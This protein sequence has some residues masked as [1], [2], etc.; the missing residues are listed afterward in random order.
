MQ[1][2]RL[3]NAGGKWD[4][5]ILKNEIFVQVDKMNVYVAPTYINLEKP[6]FWKPRNSGEQV[7]KKKTMFEN[8]NIVEIPE[9]REDS[10]PSERANGQDSGFIDTDQEEAKE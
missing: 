6:T 2:R 5:N 9:F 7:I 3:I 8:N 4:T 1:I 10:Q